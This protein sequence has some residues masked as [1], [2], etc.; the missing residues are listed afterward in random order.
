MD[1]G[2]WSSA[3]RNNYN[4]RDAIARY[5]VQVLRKIGLEKKHKLNKISQEG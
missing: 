4:L 5:T 3:S 2:Q 1:G